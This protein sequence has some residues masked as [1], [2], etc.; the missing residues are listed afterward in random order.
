MR[1]V[2]NSAGLGD[3]E[4]QVVELAAV[5]PFVLPGHVM[6]LLEA[7]WREAYDVLAG[8]T[9]AGVLVRGRVASETQDC[10]QITSAGLQALGSRSPLPAFE[11]AYEHAVCASWVWVKARSGAFGPLDRVLC[12]REMRDEDRVDG[13]GVPYAVEPHEFGGR[14]EAHYP[15]LALIHGSH[16]LPVEVVTALPEV[17][18]L[19]AVLR[20]YAA[21]HR[22]TEVVFFSVDPRLGAVVERV[23]DSLELSA[24]VFIRAIMIGSQNR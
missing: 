2:A 4:R 21:D 11:P 7:D 9:A 8:L 10:F 17:G 3:R 19:A 22:V 1:L 16:R 18:Q 15:D 20:A 13:A 24:M 6:G 12:E 14:F 23:S 5:Q